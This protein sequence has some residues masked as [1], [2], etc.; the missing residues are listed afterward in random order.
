MVFKE[1]L[2]KGRILSIDTLRGIT[3]L[4]MIFV[5][6]L[7]G[8]KNIPDWMKHVSAEADAMTFVDVVFPAFLFIVGMSIPFSFNARLSKGDSTATIWKHTLLRFCALIIIGV[9]M[10]NVSYGYDASQML[11]SKTL[12]GLLAYS[13]PILV[14]NQYHKKIVSS[15]K[16]I[17]IAIGILGYLSL[18]FLYIQEGNG[19]IGITVKWWGILGLIG[20]AYLISV[21]GYWITNRKLIFSIILL[22]ICVLINTLN[23]AGLSE[24]EGLTW[25]SAISGHFGHASITIAGLITSLL[26][27]DSPKKKSINWQVV[28][29]CALTFLIGFVL[30]PYFEVS[31]VRATPSWCLYSA[32]WCIAIYYLFY[33]LIEEKNLKNWT[34][35]F[36][37]AASNPLLI[38][39]LPGIFTYTSSLIMIDFTPEIAA[40]GMPGIIWSMLYA[41]FMMVMVKI[42]N[43]Y[44]I[45]LHL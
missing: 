35:F 4:T 16:W 15:V 14:W 8:V 10:V 37:P 19:E 29:F 3:I 11:I 26:F 41:L 40:S 1:H 22:G 20:W 34:S 13:L 9:F 5:N 39:I 42:C 12:W 17:L 33:Y 25:L 18:Y 38:Y 31:K 43:I 2:Y 45:R 44:H 23:T 32:G 7:A 6:E 36:M 27:F 21:V 24:N 28:I 30:R